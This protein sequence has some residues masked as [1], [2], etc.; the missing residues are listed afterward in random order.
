MYDLHLSHL[1]AAR[2]RLVILGGPGS[3]KS[4]FVRYLALRL[5]QAG[6][7]SA[8]QP[9][10]DPAWIHGALTPVYVELRR[11]VASEYF[12]NSLTT[13]PTAADLWN[14]I[15]HELGD[16][17]QAYAE[18]LRYDL[19]EGH[20]LLILDGLDEVGYPEGELKQRQDQLIGL[21]KSLDSRY[22][23]SRIIVTSRPYAYEGWALPSYEKVEIAPFADS[24]RRALAERLYRAVNIAD[25][26]AKVERLVEQLADIDDDLKDRPLFVTMMATLY[27]RR[28]DAGLPTE[29]S[30]LYRESIRLLLERWTNAKR[31][32]PTLT[33]ILGGKSPDDLYQ[34]LCEL[35]Y[36]VHSSSSTQKGSDDIDDMLI[37]KHLKPLGGREKA[38]VLLTY[39]SE[40]A[41]VLV[42]PGHKEDSEVF[43]FAHRSFQ[44]Y[45]AAEDLVRQCNAAQSFTLLRDHIMSKPD[46]WR[47]PSLFVGDIVGERKGDLWQVVEDV[48]GDLTPDASLAANDRQWWA[49]WLAARTVT[50]Q[51]LDDHTELEGSEEYIREKLIL[52]LVALLDT[53]QALKPKERADCGRALGNLGDLRKG[54]GVGDDGLPDIVWRAVPPPPGGRVMLGADDQED[55][56]R[57][58]HPM[59]RPFLIATYTITNRQYQTF[60]AAPDG[61]YNAVWWQDFPDRYQPQE[62]DEPFYDWPNHPRNTVSWYQAVAFTRWLNQR[63]MGRTITSETGNMSVTIGRDAVLRL[64]TEWE[65]EY[66]V[67]GTDEQIYPYGNTFDET[68][69]NT[70]ETGIGTPT[71]VGSFPDG[72]A[73]CGAMDMS[74]NVQQW[75]KNKYSKNTEYR[76]LRGGSFSN[77]RNNAAC[78]ARGSNSPNNDLNVVGFRVVVAGPSVSSDL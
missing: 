16:E 53:P 30:A 15:R 55:N 1:A 72:A 66:A 39:L 6:L 76:V 38:A 70:N 5:A 3:G 50:D 22:E 26:A 14:Y 7:P 27:N 32:A 25:A 67:R 21:A 49:V 17:L 9:A 34:R 18:D 8:E 10:L 36:A 31:G 52:W 37:I 77:N 4:T 68:K 64:P 74:G 40:N 58:E 65:W 12:P 29:R 69:V 13:I 75:C 11:F 51:H 56:L 20:A 78:A 62:L 23:K 44:E 57:R 19:E 54:V 73:W 33:K 46:V 24:H 63:W 59:D 2:D 60:V 71:A 41:G 28:A 35:A 45:L 47:V 61:Y 48:L 42:S 43:Q